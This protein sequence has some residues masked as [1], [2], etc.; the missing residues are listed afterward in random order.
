V[1][2]KHLVILQS[3]MLEK[4]LTSAKLN[5]QKQEWKISSE[6]AHMYLQVLTQKSE[7]SPSQPLNVYLLTR[8]ARK[9]VEK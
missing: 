4:C 6:F 1:Q 5:I 8:I 3:K 9:H 7:F 2:R